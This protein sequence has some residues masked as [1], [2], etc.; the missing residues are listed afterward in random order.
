[1]NLQR[2]QKEDIHY[3]YNNMNKK[4]NSSQKEQNTIIEK[5]A[6]DLYYEGKS[7]TTQYH[8]PSYYGGMLRYYICTRGR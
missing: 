5:Y 2:V 4:N 6:I 8:I 3:H 1:M 7:N